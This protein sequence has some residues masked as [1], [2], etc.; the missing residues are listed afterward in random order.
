M[1]QQMM[2]RVTCPA[3]Q[4][5]FQ[6]RVDQVLDVKQDPGAKARVLNGK[7]N[8]AQCPNCG[9]T[10]SMGLPFLYH[11]PEEELA[12]VFM[13]M[14]AGGDNE[15]RQR[16]IGQLTRAAMD[17]LPSEDRKA[18]LLDPQVFLTM[19]NLMK[20]VLKA[21]GVTEEMIEEQHARGELLR[22]MFEATS[23][24][25]LEAMIE[26]NDEAIDTDFFYLLDR[27]LEVVQDSG[28][29]NEVKKLTALRDKL[30]ELS[31]TGQEIKERNELVEE[32]R[33]NPDRDTLL[34]LLVRAPDEDAR[35]LLIS[36]GRPL[37]DYLFFQ[38][39]T[40]RIEAASDTEK[41][42]QLTSLRKNVLDIR[43]EL[44]AQIKALYQSRSQLIRDLLQSDD[45]E[46][47]IRQKAG[48]VDEVFLEILGANIQEA[49]K[50]GNKDAVQS[51][52]KIWN[53]VEGL[54]EESLPPGLRLFNRLMRAGD[55]AE[56][57]RLLDENPAFVSEGVAKSLE[58]AE[59]ETREEDPEAADQ[60]AL[61]LKTI[62]KKL[63]ADLLV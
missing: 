46:T 45:P 41:K 24:E 19:D 32:L 25:A 17:E 31:S 21:D 10:G 58:Q 26:A 12:L 23:D 51:L 53:L 30:L 61:I 38:N 34:D 60:I 33:E 52:Q 49:Q 3:C 7:V 18:Y 55:E 43:D 20:E 50:A 48:K 15:D 16:I 14:E 22:R 5:P 62:R 44:D 35:E 56:I 2:V 4:K 36:F 28:M 6:A 9:M 1:P 37:L 54:M 39:L 27:N 42:E 29:N 59:A 40:S 11:D 63:A 13:P 57:E 47:L 8:V